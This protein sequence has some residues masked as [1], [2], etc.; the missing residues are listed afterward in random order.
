MKREK[1]HVNAFL[2]TRLREPLISARPLLTREARN[3]ASTM[4][5]FGQ[6]VAK[7]SGGAIAA[8][9]SS[10]RV[11]ESLQSVQ[12]QLIRRTDAEA[13]VC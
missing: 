3:C 13:L 4:V 5:L 7:K 9:S 6:V 1:A 2:P 11:P 10:V 12:P 8:G